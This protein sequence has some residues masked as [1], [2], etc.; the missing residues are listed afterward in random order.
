[1]KIPTDM[2]NY[3]R[4]RKKYIFEVG[5]YKS[6]NCSCSAN[7]L[8]LCLEALIL[9][10]HYNPGK[11]LNISLRGISREQYFPKKSASQNMEIKAYTNEELW[12]VN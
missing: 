1:M 11:T 6:K 2:Q 7:D 4:K 5:A 8:K 12:E 9:D 3:K 10:L